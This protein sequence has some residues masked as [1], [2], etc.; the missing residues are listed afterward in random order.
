MNQNF[1]MNT[2]VQKE[3]GMEIQNQG[4]VSIFQSIGEKSSL[5]EISEVAVS[6]VVMVLI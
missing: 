5:C 2:K 3:P 4:D 6:V 1:K